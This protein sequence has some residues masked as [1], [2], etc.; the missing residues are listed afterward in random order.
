MNRSKGY[1]RFRSVVRW[2]FWLSVLFFA[3][4]LFVR[5]GEWAQTAQGYVVN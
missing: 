5:F 2:V 1:Y 4:Q 3:E